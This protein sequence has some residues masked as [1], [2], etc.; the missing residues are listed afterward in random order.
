[1]FFSIYSSFICSC[2]LRLCVMDLLSTGALGCTFRYPPFS[3]CFFYLF[4]RLQVLY[5]E[6]ILKVE[7]QSKFLLC[8]NMHC[9]IQSSIFI[10][11]PLCNFPDW[12]TS[13]DSLSRDLAC[14]VIPPNRGRTARHSRESPRLQSSSPISTLR[15][16]HCTVRPS[17]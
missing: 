1:M 13:N 9:C 15:V 16:R 12:A 5:C 10:A 3:C 7:S 17:C 6:E 14:D 11:V 2:I 8:I 4:N